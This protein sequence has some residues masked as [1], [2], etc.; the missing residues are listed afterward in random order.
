MKKAIYLPS[1]TGKENTIEVKNIELALSMSGYDFT[2]QPLD[3]FVSSSDGD[4]FDLCL[5]DQLASGGKGLQMALDIEGRKTNKV[6]III[7]VKSNI[8][9]KDDKKLLV[10]SDI[11]LTTKPILATSLARKINSLDRT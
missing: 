2:V 6:P 3:N 11:I 4:S 5:V 1:I 10:D 8:L 9:S 7:L